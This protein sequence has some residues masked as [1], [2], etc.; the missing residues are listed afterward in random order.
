[1]KKSIRLVVLLMGILITCSG[2]S[3][4]AQTSAFLNAN[5][6]RMKILIQAL[7]LWANDHGSLFPSEEEFASPVFQTYKDRADSYKLKNLVSSPDGLPFIYKRLMNGK[8]FSLS[9][10][11]PQMLG[12]SF[13]RFI[14]SKGFEK[15][16]AVSVQPAKPS[17]SGTVSPKKKADDITKK[18]AD[19]KK[20]AI[21][22]KKSTVKKAAPTHT[23]ASKQI[24][25]EKPLEDQHVKPAVSRPVNITEHVAA[26]KARMNTVTQ[27]LELWAND[28]KSLYPEISSY[29]SDAFNKYI[30]KAGAKNLSHIKSGLKY[31]RIS[32]GKDF[33]LYYNGSAEK[34]IPDITFTKSKGFKQSPAKKVIEKAEPAKSSKTAQTVKSQYKKTDVKSTPAAKPVKAASTPSKTAEKPK[35]TASPKEDYTPKEVLAAEKEEI[36]A[37]ITS[38]YN[39]YAEKDLEKVL[40]LQNESIESSALAYEKEGK[41]SAQDVRDAFRSATDEILSHKAFKMLPLNTTDLTFQK[42]GKYIRVTSVVPIIATERLELMENGKYFF[43]RLRIAEFLFAPSETGGWKILNMYL[44]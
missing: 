15:G 25:K 10:S 36:I 29:E 7:E 28:H 2:I 42:K 32:G 35:V 27:A 41:G 33:S 34:K 5:T 12:L 18:K 21:A 9:V 3:F 22:S 37:V 8:D 30:Q 23:P 4:S 1:M 13:Y 44:Y 31:T 17:V 38:L 24:S 14:H 26:V 6:V 11:N 43:V 16:S 39:A 40:Q 20:T 19:R